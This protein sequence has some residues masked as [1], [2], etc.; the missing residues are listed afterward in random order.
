M[1]TLKGD[2]ERERCVWENSG[3]AGRWSRCS[4][5]GVRHVLSWVNQTAHGI[6]N[7]QLH[8]MLAELRLDLGS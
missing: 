4:E 8:V 6:S 1:S 7:M 2:I 5:T 3:G